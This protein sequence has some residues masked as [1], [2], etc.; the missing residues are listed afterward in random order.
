MQSKKESMWHS[1]WSG[2][3]IP[4]LFDGWRP[5]SPGAHGLRPQEQSERNLLE[6]KA[7]LL[8]WERP[9]SVLCGNAFMIFAGGFTYFSGQYF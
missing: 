8:R 1:R 7:A 4:L 5:V 9:D 3:E 6:R 2:W